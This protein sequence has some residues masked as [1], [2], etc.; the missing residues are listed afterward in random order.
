MLWRS[1]G[2]RAYGR[3]RGAPG[4]DAC[5]RALADLDAIRSKIERQ[6][7][8]ALVPTRIPPAR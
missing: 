6:Q 1:G 3:S 8:Q 7:T 2:T 5:R 4:K